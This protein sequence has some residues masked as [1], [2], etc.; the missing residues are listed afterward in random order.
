MY[1]VE[2]PAAPKANTVAVATEKFN[3]PLY[4]TQGRIFSGF[5]SWEA[6]SKLL[7]SRNYLSHLQE[8]DFGAIATLKCNSKPD[9]VTSSH[10][11]IIRDTTAKG[12]TKEQITDA[13]LLGI[14][15]MLALM[16]MIARTQSLI[17]PDGFDTSAYE[18]AVQ[19]SLP[20]I[21]FMARLSDDSDMA[22]VI[23]MMNWSKEDMNRLPITELM[24]G[25]EYNES[26]FDFADD[27][28]AAL[29]NLDEIHEAIHTSKG[30]P[31]DFTAPHNG[32]LFGCPFR[33]K[34][35]HLYG[36]LTTSMVQNGIAETIYNTRRGQI[37]H[38]LG[39]QALSEIAEPDK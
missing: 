30:E 18:A 15:D 13:A 5:N 31:F 23:S 37:A 6:T 17:R 12:H 16:S 32:A 33:S 20:T 4:D 27:G 22:L 35:S 3:G 14:G 21:L 2:W 1:M 19:K 10:E 29:K 39:N 11:I 7:R 36:A 34:I 38:S 8:I 28:S 25:L 9:L 24:R 26:F